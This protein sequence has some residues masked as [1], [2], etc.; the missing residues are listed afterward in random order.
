MVISIGEYFF[1]SDS[2]HGLTLKLTIVY[3]SYAKWLYTKVV[4]AD[5]LTTSLDYY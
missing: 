3:H 1:V 5:M 2:I 4:I